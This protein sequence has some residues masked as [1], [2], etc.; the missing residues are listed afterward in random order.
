MY[1]FPALPLA[2]DWRFRVLEDSHYWRD[3][4]FP[5]RWLR[6]LV[7]PLVSAIDKLKR[8]LF[9]SWCQN[10]SLGIVRP[11][12][13]VLAPS[14]LKAFLPLAIPFIRINFPYFIFFLYFTTYIY[15]SLLVILE[16]NTGLFCI[17]FAGTTIISTSE[18]EI[19]LSF[20]FSLPCYHLCGKETLIGVSFPMY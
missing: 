8:K 19:L 10:F 3:C 17:S 7:Q 12:W 2:N 13:I 15:E 1:V 16:S 4:R 18:A 20:I 11:K 5:S 14:A 9:G 6:D